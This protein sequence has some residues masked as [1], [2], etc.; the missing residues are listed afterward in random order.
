MIF[1]GGLEIYRQDFI[2]PICAP[3]MWRWTR[4]T[5]ISGTGQRCTCCSS[6]PWEKRRV[7][8]CGCVG[9]VARFPWPTSL[10]LVTVQHLP[11]ARKPHTRCNGCFRVATLWEFVIW[12]V[13]YCLV[14]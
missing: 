10:P 5:S 14:T 12:G 7:Y 9:V 1:N 2:I 6:C 8:V 11:I 13:L 3:F 4:L